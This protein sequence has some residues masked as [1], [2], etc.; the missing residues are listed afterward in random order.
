MTLKFHTHVED[1]KWWGAGKKKK[2]QWDISVTV[3]IN[4]FGESR[5]V[6]PIFHPLRPWENLPWNYFESLTYGPGKWRTLTTVS[7]THLQWRTSEDRWAGY[8]R[9]SHRS[10][11]HVTRVCK[12]K[13]L[14]RQRICELIL[15]YQ[16]WATYETETRRG[17]GVETD[18][19]RVWTHAQS[20]G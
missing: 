16:M 12:L 9:W 2:G 19:E 4:V 13:S 15:M 7:A 1:I 17:R 18:S 10:V 6:C 20:S 5:A 11:G 3:K 8:C 14:S